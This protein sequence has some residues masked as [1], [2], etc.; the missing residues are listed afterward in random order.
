[1]NAAS[2]FVREQIEK[3]LK[4]LRENCALQR[5][6]LRNA[7]GRRWSGCERSDRNN[8]SSWDLYW[9]NLQAEAQR[10]RPKWVEAAD[11][12]L[13]DF[14]AEHRPLMGAD[15][16]GNDHGRLCWAPYCGGRPIDQHYCQLDE[17]HEG[18]HADQSGAWP[19][20][21]TNDHEWHRLANSCCHPATFGKE[22][23]TICA[24]C[25]TTLL[26]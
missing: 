18:A 8:P 20:D 5:L 25:G 23:S 3:R 24:A 12:Q 2:P 21:V 17:G 14:I 19:R 1:M 7:H 22:Q 16:V 10:E 26:P 13:S 6:H 15:W 11:K 9:E 4:E